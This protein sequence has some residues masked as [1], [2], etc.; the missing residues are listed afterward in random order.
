MM[1][2]LVKKLITGMAVL[3]I[4]VAAGFVVTNGMI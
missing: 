1:K 4:C 2:A 3:A